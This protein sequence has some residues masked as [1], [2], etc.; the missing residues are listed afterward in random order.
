MK[1]L[2]GNAGRFFK[3][4]TLEFFSQYNFR[5][6]GSIFLEKKTPLLVIPSEGYGRF[7]NT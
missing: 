2:Y 3:I 4:A 7:Q 6:E 1:I 5:S